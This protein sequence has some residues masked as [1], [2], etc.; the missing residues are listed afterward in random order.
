MKLDAFLKKKI[1]KSILFP[2]FLLTLFL[3]SFLL[4]EK[5]SQSFHFVDEE[6]HLVIGS[7]INKGYKLYR[8]LS[9]NHQPLVYFFSA[10]FQKTT[11]PTTIFLLIKR[12]REAIFLYSFIWSLFLVYQFGW[13]FLIFSLFFEL[14][15]FFIFG[16]LLL[17]ENLAVY[18]FLFIIGLTFKTAFYNYKPKNW[19]NFIFGLANF[20]IV[21]NL[22]PLIPSLL[23]FDLIFFLKTKIFKNFFFGL[24]IP[25]ITIFLF[26]SPVDWFRETIIYNFKYTVPLIS[27]IHSYKDYFNFLFFPLLSFIRNNHSIFNQFIQFFSLLLLLNLIIISFFCQKKKKIIFLWI[28]FLSLILASNN[29]VLKPGLMYYSGFH[30]LPWYSGFIFFNLL[31]IKLLISG[32][33]KT[34]K[35]ILLAGFLIGGLYLF[36]NKAMPYFLRINKN[37]EHNVNFFPYYLI[38]EA[39]KSVAGSEDRLAVLPD[40]SLIYWQSGLKPATRQIAYY[41]WQYRPLILRKQLDDILINDPPEFIYADFGRI[42]KASYLPILTSTLEKNYWRITSKGIAQNLYLKKEKIQRIKESQWQKWTSLS[43]DR[44][45]L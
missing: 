15:K 2:F 27:E 4:T 3:V 14:S 41:E 29:R 26:I 10:A 19:E 17:A 36:S 24:I 9:T 32:A 43:F 20:I 5:F 45:E 35:N 21:F 12:G 38:G 6:D 23:F 8:D 39:V 1:Y 18:P 37:Y 34:G 42:G 11:K 25:T 13:P 31:T 22:L 44:I 40:E 16:N 28:I 7:Y 30:L 33:K